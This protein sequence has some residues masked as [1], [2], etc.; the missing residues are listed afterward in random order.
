MQSLSCPTCSEKTLARAAAGACVLLA[1]ALTLSPLAAATLTVTTLNDSGA[2]SLRQCVLDAGAGDDIVCEAG[3]TGAIVLT[4]GSINLENDIT[5][6]G[7]ASGLLAVSGG[8]SS[9]IFT[10]TNV[11]TAIHQLTFIN[12]LA[13]GLN[14]GVLSQEGGGAV[15]SNCLFIGNT[16]VGA[17][18]QAGG[19]G[20]AIYAANAAL[21]LYGCEFASNTAVGPKGLPSGTA[22]YSGGGGGGAGLGGAIAM[23]GGTSFVCECTFNHNSVT[24]GVG[25]VAGWGSSSED[26]GKG[27]GPGGGAGGTAAHLNGYEGGIFSGGGGGRIGSGSTG[28]AG[29]FGGGGGGSGAYQQG[30]AGGAGGQYGGSGSFSIYSAGGGGGGGGGLGGAIFIYDSELTITNSVLAGNTASGGHGGDAP[31]P[32]TNGMG[33]GGAV[34]IHGN[35]TVSLHQV[36]FYDNTADAYSHINAGTLAVLGTNGATIASGEEP[37]VDKGTAMGGVIANG[38]ITNVLTLANNWSIPIAISAVATNGAGASAFTIIGV[39][40]DLPADTT[41][42]F[43]VV[44]T[45]PAEGTYTCLVSIIN[46]SLSAPYLLALS[47]TGLP[48]LNQVISNMLPISGSAFLITNTVRLSAQAGSGLAVSFQVR[49]GP[50]ALS[51]GTNLAFSNSG[52]V[53]VVASQAGDATWNPASPVTGVYNVSKLSQAGLVFAPP[54]TQIYR[55]TNIL[56]ATGGSGTGAVTYAVVS[57]PG[58]IIGL[59]KL[60]ALSGTGK[61]RIRALK[62]ADS[63][64]LA[65]AI[66]ATVQCAKAGQVILF[67]AVPDQRRTNAVVLSASASSGLAVNYSVASGPGTISNGVLRFSRAGRVL[68]VA[69]QAGNTNF[70]AAARVTNA[71][72]ATGNTPCDY[73]GTGATALSMYDPVGGKWYICDK[74]GRV[75]AWGMEWGGPNMVPVNGDFDGD[76]LGDPAVYDTTNGKWYIRTMNNVVLAWGLAWG[77]AGM[78][79]VPGD[80]NGDRATDLAVFDTSS[81]KWYIQT[82]NEAILVWG[83]E[84]G[85]AGM[86]PVSGDYD[87]DEVSD[88]CVYDP[89]NGRWFA[90]SAIQAGKSAEFSEKAAGV[91]AWNVAWGGSGMSAV[92]GDFDGDQLYDLA[93]YDQGTGIWFVRS[94]AGTMLAWNL[95][96]G[97]SGMIAVPGDFDGDL[98]GDAVVYRKSDGAWFAWSVKK[99]AVIPVDTLWG[100]PGLEP[101]AR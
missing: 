51:G 82:L 13:N 66:T 64:Y 21:S 93:V 61:I 2:G 47:G 53:E 28:G 81:G 45:P 35:S 46:S 24:G 15:F 16:A 71:V 8:N 70:S 58:Q 10:A 80:Y 79:P 22:S 87:G 89:V 34:L 31:L 19:F 78:E 56:S 63:L 6:T 39:P 96:W 37:S 98:A 77:G 3:L 25:G 99:Q 40:S 57:G 12:A 97:G 4:S 83:R 1:G 20:G 84:W 101:V 44:F 38:S 9:R 49:S 11:E 74:S 23:I 43:K 69:S 17:E 14:G 62:G 50:A 73:S 65:G 68:V 48:K 60:K 91:I 90:S 54:A 41:S 32:G 94:V 33:A 36:T 59:N 100:G 92:S 18:G 75:V 85:G 76:G 72:N 30:T 95:A 29:G 67:P 55:T 52:R 5:I 88:L 42:L 27:G 7:P 86:E 26:G